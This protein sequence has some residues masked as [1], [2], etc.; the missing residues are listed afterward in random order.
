MIERRQSERKQVAALV[1]L[2]ASGQRF[3]RCKASDLSAGGTFIELEP[4]AL[5]RGRKVQLVFVLA[6]GATIKLHRLQ[7][8]VARVTRTGAGMSLHSKLP[9]RHVGIMP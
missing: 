4:I 1:Y 9:R 6:A 5:R 3:R 2:C 7:A 8:V